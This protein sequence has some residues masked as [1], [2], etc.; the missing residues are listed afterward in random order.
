MNGVVYDACAV[1]PTLTTNKGEGN[2]IAVPVDCI[3]DTQGFDGVRVYED[4]A[5]TLRSQRGGLK[6]ALPVLTP[7]RAEKRQNGRGFKDDGEPMFTLT[8]QDKHGVGIG[9]LRTVRNDYGKEIRKQYEAG[10]LDISRHDFLEHDIREDG[11]TNTI[12][13]VQK[14]NLLA[15]EM[16]GDLILPGKNFNQKKRVHPPGGLCRT[17]TGSGSCGTEPKVMIPVWVEDEE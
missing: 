10:E 1:G 6:V 14:D 8:G 9:V 13:T 11:I 12:S 16:E 3:D 7:D 5:P 15:V 4:E 17:L 2:K